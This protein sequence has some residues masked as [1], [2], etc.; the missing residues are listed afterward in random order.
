[1]SWLET[2]R[3]SLEAIA[4]HRLRSTLTVIGILIGI[5]AVILTV[6][7]G[8]GAQARVASAI[9]SLG[10][11]L[12]VVLPG[13]SSNNGIQ[14]G[15]G[16]A[17]T[18]TLADAA[19]LGSRVDDPDVS[20]VAPTVETGTNLV[21]SS[22]NW[23][24]TVVGT[25]PA[26]LPIR[27][28]RMLDGRFFDT[29]DVREA[30]AV[31]VLGTTTAQKLFGSVDPVGKQVTIA[32]LPYTVIGVLA[33]SGSSSATNQDDQALLPI[34]TAEQQQL[35][36]GG[37]S[38]QSIL[39]QAKSA[40]TLGAAYQEADAELLSLHDITDPADADFTITT[41][42]A[43]LQTATSVDQTL[44]VLLAGVAGISLLVGGIGVMNIMLV[45][46]AERVREIGLR[47][48]LGATPRL[49]RRQFLLEASMLG[50]SGGAMGVALGAI[51]ALVLPRFVSNPVE[52]S[53][54]AVVGAL[55]VAVGIGLI[56]GVY[57]AT[58]AARLAP[59]DALRLE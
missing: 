27:D 56:F 24:T 34:S 30:A 51:A 9:T 50:L 23:T 52:I 26:W 16:T 35:F 22:A 41:Q 47:K 19:A 5:A 42:T 33:A 58:R 28:R 46:V 3:T 37:Q 44:T 15:G 1:M 2:M 18:L 57:P 25:T 36:G 38:V 8:Q 45:S 49:I 53:P 17:G 48:A 55:M 40:T 29:A 20:R 11:N 6:G 32:G 39:L 31:V 43:L 54:L 4:A 21:T 59:I 14:L 13:S 7:F 12:L 10:T